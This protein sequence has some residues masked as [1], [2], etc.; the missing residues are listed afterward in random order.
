VTV[1]REAMLFKTLHAQRVTTDGYSVSPEVMEMKK[2]VKT[3]Y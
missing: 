2:L 3:A 1:E